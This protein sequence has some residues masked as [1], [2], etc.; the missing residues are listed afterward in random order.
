MFYSHWHGFVSFGRTAMIYTPSWRENYSLS[1]GLLQCLIPAFVASESLSRRIPP[2]SENI[3]LKGFGGFSDP[4]KNL[5]SVHSIMKRSRIKFFRRLSLHLIDFRLFTI[6]IYLMTK[7]SDSQDFVINPLRA[8]VSYFDH[9][10]RNDI[11]AGKWWTP[12]IWFLSGNVRLNFY[13]SKCQ[14]RASNFSSARRYN[15]S[16]ISSKPKNPWN[17]RKIIKKYNF[18]T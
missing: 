6:V 15:W 14:A 3:F 8:A 1:D 17:F 9:F 16:K 11:R 10:F 12:V 18:R 7:S 4:D 13:F 2:G 5:I